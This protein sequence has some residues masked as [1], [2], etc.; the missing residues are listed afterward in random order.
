MLPIVAYLLWTQ[1]W[2]RFPSAILVVL[3]ALAVVATGYSDEWMNVLLFVSGDALDSP[4]NLAP[5][6]F[7]G[8][9]WVPMAL[10]LATL[11][12]WRRRIGL[13]AVAAN[14]YVLPHYLLLLLLELTPR[15]TAQ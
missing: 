12:V 1:P 10:V 15:R 4:F 5:S 7:L 6:R 2:L 3:N 11:F 9:A 14:P 13:A 8:N